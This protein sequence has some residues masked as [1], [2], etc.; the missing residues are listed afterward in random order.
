MIDFE[1]ILLNVGRHVELD[2][3]ETEYFI[4]LLKSRRLARKALLLKEGQACNYFY[5]VHSGTLRAFCR[6]DR[7]RESTIMF[8]PADWWVTDMYC[9]LNRRKAMMEI[10]ALEASTVFQ[11]SRKQLDELLSR[12]PKFERWFRILM[13]NAY[14][15]EQLR[16][17]DNL[18]LPAEER[19][20]R[21]VE[22]Y[23]LIA[24]QVTQKQIASYLGITPEFLSAIRK[25]IK[26]V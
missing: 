6:D 8:A 15:R 5:Y 2:A 23:P 1:S 25:K 10:E 4:S 22:R 12:S 21:F 26:I 13:Q 24:A 9:F 3:E 18:S 20:R 11:L 16:A 7:G 14:T 17:I 19:Y